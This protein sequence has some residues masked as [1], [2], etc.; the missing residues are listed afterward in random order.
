L[1]AYQIR[2]QDGHGG[3]FGRQSSPFR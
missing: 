1:G 2:V 3:L